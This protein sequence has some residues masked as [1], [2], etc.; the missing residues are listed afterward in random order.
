MLTALHQSRLG[1]RLSAMVTDFDVSLPGRQ[2]NMR[3]QQASAC[4]I[5]LLCISRCCIGSH[6]HA[7]AKLLPIGWP[8]HCRHRKDEVSA[9]LYAQFMLSLP[10]GKLILVYASQPGDGHQ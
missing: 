8:R 3:W 10:K 2:Y 9:N 6:L 1:V 4:D 7:T 5:P